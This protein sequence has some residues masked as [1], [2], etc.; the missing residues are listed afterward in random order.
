MHVLYNRAHLLTKEV[1]G[2]CIEVHRLQGP[3]LLESIYERCLMRELELRGLSATKQQIIKIDYKGL[4]FE[5][6]L[7]YDVLVENCL[8]VEVKAVEFVAPIHKA[9]LMSYMKL[10]GIPL[11]LV[12]NFHE[13]Q[14]RD[15]L[16]RLIL[17]GA[18]LPPP[19]QTLG[20]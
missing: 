13:L 4:V 3:G 15:G 9:K 14:L 6:V 17:P 8:L 18:N 11:G 10:L 20:N 1:I 7:R 12:V 16:S 2:A 19:D 5:E